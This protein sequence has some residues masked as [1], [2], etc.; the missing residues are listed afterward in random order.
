[1]YVSIEGIALEHFSA[2]YQET[3]SSYLQ[4][5]THNY[6]F[7]SFISDN[8]KK[9]SATTVTHRKQIIKLSKKNV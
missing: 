1:M 9:Y 3:I 4:I 2:A 5:H 6:V 7:H 8:I